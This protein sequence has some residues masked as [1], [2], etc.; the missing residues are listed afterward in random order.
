LRARS[1]EVVEATS[2]ED[3]MATMASDSG[4]HCMLLNWNQAHDDKKA[5]AQATDL[6]R[7]VRKRNA[8]LPIFP[9]GRPR[10]RGHSQRR[11]RNAR[12]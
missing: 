11:S 6:L 7:A 3:G 1:I 9:D 12:R 4:I 8:K 2:L 10:S 5:Y